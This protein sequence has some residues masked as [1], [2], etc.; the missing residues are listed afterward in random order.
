MI[1]LCW[2]SYIEADEASLDEVSSR[3][4]ESKRDNIR[5]SKVVKQSKWKPWADNQMKTLTDN[6][7][8]NLTEKL[9]MA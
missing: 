7:M 8:K 9:I 5:G 4:E 2:E 6:Q 3:R 1:E